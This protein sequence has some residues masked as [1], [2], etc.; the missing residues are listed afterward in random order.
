MLHVFSI[1]VVK[2]EKVWPVRF[3][4]WLYFWDRVVSGGWRFLESYVVTLLHKV[5]ESESRARLG[6]AGW[7]PAVCRCSRAGKMGQLWSQQ[8]PCFSVCNAKCHASRHH[9][10]WSVP[11][12][13]LTMRLELTWSIVASIWYTQNRNC[14][15][16]CQKKLI[17]RSYMSIAMYSE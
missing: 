6:L 5:T 2:V 10:P 3:P 4:R 7:V 15:L 1:N 8:R 9:T 17:D 14:Y 11:F 16:P 12:N 13:L